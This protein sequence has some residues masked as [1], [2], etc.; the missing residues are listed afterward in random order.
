MGRS[1]TSKKVASPYSAGGGGSEYEDHVGAYYLA[2]MLLGAVPRGQNV[3]AAR[4]IQVQ[5]LYRGEPLDDLIVRSSLPQGEMK[6]ALQIKR[7]LT[8]G[9]KD[10]TF[11]DVIHACW[12]TF[13]EASFVC[14]FDRFGIALG[15]YS[16]TIDE[17]YK[18][19]LAWARTSTTAADFFL[20]LSEKGPGHQTQRTFVELIRKKL[21][22]YVDEKV[23][24]DDLW[25]FLRSMVLLH[26]D[27]QQD[28]SRDQAYTIDLLSHALPPEQK[29]RAADLFRRLV[30]YAARANRTGGSFNLE[31]LTEQLIGDG[32]SL[33][34]APDCR[35][36]LERLK[37]HANFILRDIRADI[38]GLVLNRTQALASIQEQ[39][40]T[41]SLLELVG[42]PGVGKSALLKAL[43]EQDEGEGP[44]I[45]L[46]WDRLSGTGWSGFAQALQLSQPLQ[47][48]LLAISGS[49]SP[50]VFIEGVDRIT[51]GG[52]R[53]VVNDLLRSIAELSFVRN[54]SRPW[55]VIVTT[56]EE[57]LEEVHRWL[58]WAALGQPN[59]VRI[60]ELSAE[61]MQLLAEKRPHLR[62][63]F[64]LPQLASIVRNP[65]LLRILDDRRILTLAGT[66]PPIATEIEVG[67][68]WWEYLVG[69]METNPLPGLTRKQA[70]LTIGKRCI[71][72][73]GRWVPCE[74]IEASA[75]HS[76]VS[77]SI[78]LHDRTRDVYR[79]SH[80]V[81][82]DWI[83][84]R[85]LNQNREELPAYLQSIHEPL[86]L[87]RAVQLLGTSVLERQRTLI[88]VQLLQQME[89]VSGLSPKWRQ[90]LLMAPVRTPHSREI[91]DQ[92]KP[93]LL[94]NQAQRLIELLTLLRTVEVLPDVSLL[95]VVEK[96]KTEPS[97]RLPL[98]L[99]R[100]VP[101]WRTWGPFLGWFLAQPEAWSRE[102]Q[103]EMARLMELWQQH[104]PYH[105]TAYRQEIGS[106]AFRW[107]KEAE[108]TEDDDEL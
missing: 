43:I 5:S 103:M 30:A 27:F 99:S 15:L 39:M 3:A 69:L 12:I 38:G 11:D 104:T 14:G 87:Q 29:T 44:P 48:L 53:K 78:L 57:N 106:R 71:L 46:A 21:D 2:M 84:S 32:F 28:D 74:D 107:L 10:D 67:E 98:L 6:L 72:F 77:D 62:P 97:D 73:P 92:V 100:P 89:K 34:P 85:I 61:E 65:F 4:E 94:E 49:T 8:F 59:I 42:A 90:S 96:L 19:T 13:T 68:A 91:L 45:V 9:E 22:T 47:V 33:L 23:S 35:R 16:K 36:D 88:W 79:L 18:N 75:L 41:A 54:A 24:D 66:F 80:D 56:R 17:Y 51:D 86:G 63:L 55:K 58:D 1:R 108:R 37:E 20:R 25:H 81:L 83:F 40:H 26:F 50:R 7:D 64:S 52:A 31:T 102:V 95:P 60:D 93:Y 101:N 70:L 82:Q 76:L 105:T